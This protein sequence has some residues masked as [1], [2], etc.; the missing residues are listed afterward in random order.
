MAF[1]SSLIWKYSE[2]IN[3]I[4]RN[5]IHITSFFSF[6]SPPRSSSVSIQHMTTGR[7]W[8]EWNEKKSAKSYTTYELWRGVPSHIYTSARENCCCWEGVLIKRSRKSFCALFPS[9]NISTII[10]YIL[11]YTPTHIS[12]FLRLLELL[13]CSISPPIW[14]V[15][16]FKLS[17][18]ESTT[19]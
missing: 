5:D 6:F 1:L 18:E 3:K 7:V 10:R 8:T 2:K 17:V 19:M 16:F 11:S 4:T 9:L 12:A 13:F 14:L 15:K